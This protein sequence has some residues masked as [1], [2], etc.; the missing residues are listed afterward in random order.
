M[1]K[2][3]QIKI[4]E[5]RWKRPNGGPTCLPIL[6]MWAWNFKNKKFGELFRKNLSFCWG[7]EGHLLT[8][9][10][11]WSFNSQ[12]S[13]GLY[14]HILFGV[15]FCL[16]IKNKTSGSHGV[17][18]STLRNAWEWDWSFKGC[19]HCWIMNA[20]EMREMMGHLIIDLDF[21]GMPWSLSQPWWW[22]GVLKKSQRNSPLESWYKEF[23]IFWI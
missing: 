13:R 10:W 4:K 6:Y 18:W 1:N 5:R 11:L 14:V 20:F 19:I 7:M 23:Y 2:N 12:W 8:W 9:L 17:Q 22:L 3:N 16:L 15:R 21:N